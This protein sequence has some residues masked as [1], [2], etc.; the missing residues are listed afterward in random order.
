MPGMDFGCDI[1]GSCDTSQVVVPLQSI[2][3]VDGAAQMKHFASEGANTFRIPVSWQF[4]TNNKGGTD[5]D[6][7]KFGEFQAVMKACLDTG[8]YC[9]IDLHNFA[10]YDSGIIGQGGPSNDEFTTLWKNIAEPYKGNDKVIFGLMNEPHDLNINLWAETCQAVV[11]GLRN[12]G[13]TSQIILLPG[14]NFTSVA[15]MIDNGSAAALLNVTNPDGSTDNL[16]LDIHK[17]LDINNSGTH[18]ACV[19]NNVQAFDDLATYLRKAGRKGF[20][21]ETGASGDSSCLTMF[22]QQNEA[23]AKNADVYQG[24]TGWGAGSFK[25]DY[26]LTLTPIVGSN[27]KMTDQKIFTQCLLDVWENTKADVATPQSSSSTSASTST[28][29]ASKTT[30]AT[31]T[32]SATQ[33]DLATPTSAASTAVGSGSR[34]D[35]G[36]RT[37]S[38]PHPSVTG[39]ASIAGGSAVTV[40]VAAI[41]AFLFML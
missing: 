6:S 8:A 2:G 20:I 37:V 32:A 38:S 22:C 25:Q 9:Q 18:A 29:S 13:A 24:L 26:I 27:G 5:L 30:S 17:Y 3:G 35:S 19:M 10:R 21:S 11:N 7:T 31:K 1:D 28:K 34:L 12:S 16:L 33:K 23:I 15:T 41:G 36:S 39:G 4:L 14:N 40:V